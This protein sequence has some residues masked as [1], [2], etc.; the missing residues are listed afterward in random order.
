MNN[1][2]TSQRIP[3]M[4]TQS[5]IAAVRESLNADRAALREAVDRV[6]PAL[7]GRKPAPDR[8]SVAEVLEHLVIV[9]GRVVM[10]LGAMIPTAPMVAE[11][12]AGAATAIDR[13]ALRDRVNRITA[14][15][16]IQP[17]GAMS[18]DEAWASLERSRVQL[19]GLLDTAEGRDLTHI[20][21]Q[22]PV[23]GPLDGYQWIAAIGGHEE[24]HA[25]QILEIAAELT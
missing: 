21:R 23:L 10:M 4:S 14:P 24:R 17:T 3:S 7:R 12:A 13:V 8:W 6:P 2:L 11:S 5:P 22:H 19:H 18:A 25:A 20:S 15:D 16:A 1:P 9:E